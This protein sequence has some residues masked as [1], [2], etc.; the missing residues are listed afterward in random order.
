MEGG[1]RRDEDRDLD[2]QHAAKQFI[3]APRCKNPN[4]ELKPFWCDIFMCFT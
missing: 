3:F 2:M 1:M 4:T